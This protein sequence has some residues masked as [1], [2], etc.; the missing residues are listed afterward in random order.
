MAML[1]SY[2]NPGWADEP[3]DKNQTKIPQ[4]L[5]TV[6][7]DEP[8]IAWRYWELRGD[9]PDVL[10]SPIR[11][12]RW[13]SPILR[14]DAPPLPVDPFMFPP[15]TIIGYGIFAMKTREGLYGE[16]FGHHFYRFHLSHTV[17][18]QPLVIG[19]VELFG[20]VIE[21]EIGYRAELVRIKK[22]EISRK[23]EPVMFLLEQRYQCDVEVT[24]ANW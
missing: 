24:N 22:L 21:H 3:P 1:N 19:A 8:I 10:R 23:Y 7:S 9:Q 13:L 5:P 12:D 4:P 14:A 16:M 18:D 6:E 20:T 11:G 2:Y 17:F 15:E